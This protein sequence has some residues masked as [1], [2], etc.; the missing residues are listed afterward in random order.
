MMLKMSGG[1][2]WRDR[3]SEIG[4]DQGFLTLFRGVNIIILTICFLVCTHIPAGETSN[5]SLRILL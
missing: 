2:N 1:N 5:F 4:K 3:G